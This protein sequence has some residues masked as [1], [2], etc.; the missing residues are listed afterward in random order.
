MLNAALVETLTGGCHLA[1]RNKKVGVLARFG[2]LEV[3]NAGLLVLALMAAGC[4]TKPKRSPGLTPRVEVGAPLKSDVWKQ[5]ATS[6]D[7]DR[8]SRLDSA[9]DAALAD[10]RKTNAADVR[11]EG[12]LLK[13]DAAIAR[14][15]PTPAFTLSVPQG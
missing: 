1:G 15:A 11:R 4:E 5:V 8:L 7:E 2:S 10:A 9:W 6:D 13:P 3:R 14:P 12:V